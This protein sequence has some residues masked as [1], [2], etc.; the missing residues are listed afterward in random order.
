MEAG[1]LDLQ[2]PELD[3]RLD[4]E[5][6]VVQLRR[7]DSSPSYQ[8][9]EECMLL[10]NVA[11]AH[12]LAASGMPSLYRTHEEPDEMQW[13][14]MEDELRVLGESLGKRCREDINRIARRVR[15]APLQDP[16]NLAILRNLKRAMYQPDLAPHFGL[17]F[18]EYTHFTSPIR[19]YPDLIVHRLLDALDRKAR[20]PYTK[21]ELAE[22][23]PHCNA[24]ERAADEASAESVEVKRLAYYAEQLQEGR[25]G[26]YPAMVSGTNSR[27]VLVE[28]PDTLLRGMIPFDLALRDSRG[29][30]SGRR[31]TRVRGSAPAWNLGDRLDVELVRVDTVRRLVDFRPA[32]VIGSGKPASSPGRP[33]RRQYRKH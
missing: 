21:A 27:G 1:S 20:A 24:T 33:A 28:L 10:A 14:R 31:E 32:G 26:P 7:R 12:R 4:A 25:T 18:D 19:R 16:F 23:A 17:A 30:R 3:C 15:G 5:G 8:M 2:I 29:G 13:A 11:M 9:I 6:R 22:L